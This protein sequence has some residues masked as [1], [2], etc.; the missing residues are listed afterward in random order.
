MLIE[1]AGE[2]PRFL[3]K[4]LVEVVDAMMQVKLPFF[5]YTPVQ[6]MGCHECTGVPRNMCIT[7]GCMPSSAR[8]SL[9]PCMHACLPAYLSL[10]LSSV[11]AWACF[12]QA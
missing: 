11:R 5:V 3:R 4:Q 9:R 7:E 12:W 8:Q 2:H 10:Q 6:E 1:V